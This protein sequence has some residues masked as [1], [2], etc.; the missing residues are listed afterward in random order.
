MKLGIAGRISLVVGLLLFLFF[1][2]SAVSYI[3]TER[4]EDDLARLAGVDDLR[5]DAVVDMNIRLAEASGAAL[6]YIADGD[7]ADKMRTNEGSA[8]FD[9]SATTFLRLATSE[10]EIRL[11]E[12]V[13]EGFGRLRALGA[14]IMAIAE[15]ERGP[16]GA[17][18]S[19][20]PTID[21]EAPRARRLAAAEPLIFANA[22]DGVAGG[23]MNRKRRLQ[24]E[25]V[26]QRGRIEGL[27]GAQ[28]LP[29]A[30]AARARTQES[31]SFSAYIAMV[32]ILVT[33]GLGVVIGGG[34][35]LILA[36][37]VIRP[38]RELGASAGTIGKG[39]SAQRFVVESDDEIGE[40]AES[41][42]R[43]ARMAES[44]E[45][46]ERALREMAHHDALTKLPNRTLFQIRLVE[47]ME[48]AR[49]VDRMVALHLLDLDRFKD[50]NDTLG[51]RA[52]DALLQQV[53][54]RLRRCVRK[55]DT[56]ARLG[57][58]EFV[59]VQTNLT[60]ANDIPALAERLSD[61]LG[62]PYDLDGERVYTGASVG[63]TV[64]PNDDSEVDALLKNADLALYRAKQEGGGGFQLFDAE[65][66]VELRARKALEQDLR[67]G[68]VR[69]EFFVQYQPQ[70][71]LST[72]RIVGAEALSRW[73]HPE[74]GPIVPDDFIP[75][76]EQSGLISLLTE[77]VLRDACANAKSWKDAGLS[78]LRVSVNLSPVDFKRN[79]I[80]SLVT[81][82]IEES[83]I[84]PAMLDLEITEGMV[85]SGAESVIAT[86]YELH[87][88]GVRVS[89]DDFGTG[90]SSMG[91]LKRFPIDRLK[92]DQ[93]L[94]RDMLAN[95]E[96][97]SIT[98][99]IILLGHSLGL[100]V[101]AEGVED[102][103]QLEF[104]GQCGCD[105]AQG[106][107]IGAPLDGDEFVEFVANHAPLKPVRAAKIA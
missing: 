77:R 76:A 14:E 65:M 100:K 107:H 62:Q 19:R 31:A 60:D 23:A 21:P 93:T 63:V 47:A 86:L 32:Y 42:I 81:E 28:I 17:I 37:R 36:Q 40:L 13:V 41:M 79:D 99:V 56:V 78:E 30:R 48:N 90:F 27:L 24:A 85:M 67:A 74:R 51:H 39:M 96:D 1:V 44:R 7:L 71:D 15:R 35:A 91:Y 82:I 102:E 95:R 84:D 87:A 26:S 3:L 106:Y 4:I 70:I 33:T 75:V 16:L 54:G 49:R 45:E 34:G 25:Y 57:G 11:G 38:I 68:L 46:T 9:R 59:I 66:N 72:G 2:T 20:S 61:T 53:A 64:F 103:A 105:E 92:I 12:E 101:V 43:L 88:L 98:K 69:G 80:V 55:S 97:A 29:L 89:I 104:L 22:G 73:H 50:V 10:L 52:G 5:H 94:V 18:E 8:Q 6:A 83:G 58:D